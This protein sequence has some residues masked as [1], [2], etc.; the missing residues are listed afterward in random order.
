MSNMASIAML[1]RGDLANALALTGSSYLFSRLFKNSID[2]EKKTHDLAIEQLQKARVEWAQKREE[3]INFINKKLRLESKAEA[4]F[5]ELNDA[6]TEYHKVFGHQL[7]PLPREPVLPV[8]LRQGCDSILRKSAY[9]LLR[10]GLLCLMAI[11][12][13]RV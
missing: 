7:L 6:M 1:T 3:R 4:K 9:F 12:F 13:C 8:M 2:K 5:T 11:K 10:Q